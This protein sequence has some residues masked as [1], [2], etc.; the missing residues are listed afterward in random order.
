[1]MGLPG[2]RGRSGECRQRLYDA[3]QQ[4]E[5]GRAI[6]EGNRDRMQKRAA[7][8]CQDQASAAVSAGPQDDPLG[9]GTE[10]IGADVVNEIGRAH[11]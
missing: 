9:G 3:M 8:V 2:H 5:E 11:V 4:S 10:A 6:L 7:D 1:M